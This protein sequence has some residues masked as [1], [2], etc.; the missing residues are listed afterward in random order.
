M[1]RN[2]G[3]ALLLLAVYAAAGFSL[4]S[5]STGLQ[6]GGP[7]TKKDFLKLV[8]S[9]ARTNV[10]ITIIQRQGIAFLPT[11][12]ILKK[13][14]DAKVHEDIRKEL[15]VPESYSRNLKVR[16]CQYSR[17]PEMAEAGRQL[18]E[19]MRLYLSDA[20]HPAKVAV[21]WPLLRGIP[22]DA[23]VGPKECF[24]QSHP[25][26]VGKSYVTITGSI[27]AARGGEG[28]VDTVFTYY[29]LEDE[30]EALGSLK[31]QDLSRGSAEQ[32]IREAMTR[33]ENKLK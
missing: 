24:D 7:M 18:D 15:K 29:P 26:E 5:T 25:K 20:K 23:V 30:S 22:P 4:P 6:S 14:K 28:L 1:R 11:P 33:L 19:D 31:N 10:I 2:V 8:E 16:V 12:T 21:F 27:R 32:I 9:E 17:P 3:M 13:L